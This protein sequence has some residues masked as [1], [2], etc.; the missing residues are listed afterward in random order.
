MISAHATGTALGDLAE[1]NAINK[2]FNKYSDSIPVTAPKAG[3]RHLLG[4]SGAVETILT[5]NALRNGFIAGSLN[6]LPHDPRIRLNIPHSNI[7]IDS[8]NS[9]AVKNNFAFGGHNVSLILTT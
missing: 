9:I 7:K 6:S 5:I 3:L 8:K 2:V 4:A 1:A